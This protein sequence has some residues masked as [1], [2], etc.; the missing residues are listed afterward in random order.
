MSLLESID[1][2]LEVDV[3]GGELG[4][5]G[6]DG[7]LAAVLS[8]QPSCQAAQQTLSSAWPSCS[9]VYWKVRE[10][11]GV[12]EAPKVLGIYGKSMSYCDRLN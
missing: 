12:M 6:R 9:L 8:Q 5:R 7:R 2:L 4:L 1:A 10:A 11:K 3:V